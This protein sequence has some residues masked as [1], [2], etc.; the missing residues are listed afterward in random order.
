MKRTVCAVI[1]TMALLS[2]SLSCS[3]KAASTQ[4]PP[5]S[6]T[7]TSPAA[8][9]AT[10][11]TLARPSGGKPQELTFPLKLG[12]SVYSMVV[13]LA[14]GE[15]LDLD[16]KFVSTPQAGVRFMFT[17]PDGREMDAK[18]QPVNLPG[19]PLYDQNLPS[20]NL[21][22]VVGSHV[23]IKV[24]QDKYC[25]DGYYSLIFYGNSAQAGTVYLRYVLETPAK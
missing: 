2:S 22:E 19:H 16:W 7:G 11:T 20:Q 21:A 25:G 24:G 4:T 10:A 23:V 14:S 12:N 3:A 6:Q 5:A 15:T 17:T 8:A 13:F 1:V 18:S 9:P